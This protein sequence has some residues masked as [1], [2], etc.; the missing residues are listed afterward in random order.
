MSS[1]RGGLLD[2][3]LSRLLACGDQAQGV[4]T[5]QVHQVVGLV[6]HLENDINS[7]RSVWINI[8]GYLGS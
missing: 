4:P 1:L 3:Q 6:Y 5:G 7:T 2:G 8:N